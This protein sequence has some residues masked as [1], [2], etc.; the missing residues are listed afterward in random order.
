MGHR[1]IWTA[2]T[3]YVGTVKKYSKTPLIWINWDGEPSG[4]AE[5][6]DN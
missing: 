2:F 6:P 1:S 5:N 3:V 4:Y